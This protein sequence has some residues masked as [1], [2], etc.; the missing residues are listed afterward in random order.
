MFT[1]NIFSLRTTRKFMNYNLFKTQMSYFSSGHEH[2][3][4]GNDHSHATKHDG[5]GDHGHNDHG[6]GNHEH[7]EN[8]HGDHGHGHHHVITGEVDLNRVYVPLSREV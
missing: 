7:G 6:H 4:D 3:N 5:H 8:G 2:K 1:K